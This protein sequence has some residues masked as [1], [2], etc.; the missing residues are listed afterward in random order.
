MNRF[1]RPRTLRFH[2]PPRVRLLCLWVGVLMTVGGVF[3]SLYTI[4][5][6]KEIESIALLSNK[7]MTMLRVAARKDAEKLQEYVRKQSE[8]SVRYTEERKKHH[9][10]FSAATLLILSGSMILKVRKNLARK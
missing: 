8:L 4:N 3:L 1:F 7:E 10:L 9:F 2:L 5:Q 6:R